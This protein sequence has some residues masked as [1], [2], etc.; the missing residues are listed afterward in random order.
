MHREVAVSVL[1]DALAD[2]RIVGTPPSSVRGLCAD[3]RRVEELRLGVATRDE[4][5]HRFGLADPEE[6]CHLDGAWLGQ[7]ALDEHHVQRLIAQHARRFD[8]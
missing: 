6:P 3:S 4:H 8:R 2:K 1:L 5:D 7:R